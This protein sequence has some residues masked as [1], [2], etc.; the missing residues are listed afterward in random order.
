MNYLV[1]DKP[2]A[3]HLTNPRHLSR[4]HCYIVKE[5]PGISTPTASPLRSKSRWLQPNPDWFG[6]SCTSS[7]NPRLLDVCR[8]RPYALPGADD[9]PF[10]EI[11]GKSLR[12]P[13]GIPWLPKSANLNGCPRSESHPRASQSKL[14]IN[15]TKSSSTKSSTRFVL[16]GW[17][18]CMAWPAAQLLQLRH[19]ELIS[20]LRSDGGSWFHGMSPRTYGG[21]LRNPAPVDRLFIPLFIGVEPSFWWC[22]I[23]QPS[24]V[25]IIIR[26]GDALNPIQALSKPPRHDVHRK[27][28]K[29]LGTHIKIQWAMPPFST[30]ADLA[31]WYPI[32]ICWL[33]MVTS[34]CPPW[35]SPITHH[36][37]TMCQPT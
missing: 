34:P 28:R 12:N 11:N 24:T 14:N 25:S 9:G 13:K 3:S 20:L 2:V 35:T 29:Y 8:A 4:Y 18:G 15:S 32:G 30:A 22:R 36:Q 27:W 23:L 1:S 17:I 5:S 26:L 37:D 19:H 33:H 31:C 7:L 6:C 16:F 10:V 21:W